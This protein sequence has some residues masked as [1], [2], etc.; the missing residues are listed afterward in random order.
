[1]TN[2]YIFWKLVTDPPS[3]FQ[4]LTRTNQYLRFDDTT[5][6][7][8]TEVGSATHNHTISNYSCGNGSPTLAS[9]GDT[10]LYAMSQHT[11]AEPSS[12]TV[13]TN[14]NNPPA[15]G[16]DIIY[17]DLT[18]FEQLASL[19]EGSVVIS[20]GQLIDENLSRFS[21]AD[22]KYI[23]N[24]EPGTTSGTTTPQSPSVSGN[25]GSTGSIST[26]KSGSATSSLTIPLSHSHSIS[27]SS[28]A[29]YSEPRNLVT[30]LYEVVSQ[31]SRLLQE[32]VIFVDGETGSNWEILDSWT[33]ANLK[34]GNS[35]P[36]ISGSDTHTHTFSGNSGNNSSGSKSV[37][38]GN[39]VYSVS[40][41]PHTHSVSGTLASSSHIP[42]SRKVIP[43]RLLTTLYPKM[44][45]NHAQL[46]GL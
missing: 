25:T 16:L 46:I 5:S 41:Q 35:D 22:G 24:A 44:V 42:S 28:N 40:T 26:V 45:S 6:N 17:C 29:L 7:H 38:Y 18:L 20:N 27:L 32:T 36:T 4:R 1:M 39:D 33:G 19:P 10:T 31:T 2:A 9:S 3:P 23:I 15:Y 11:H 8:W 34:S 43:V 21:D 30:R 37:A 13:A 12:W 14:N